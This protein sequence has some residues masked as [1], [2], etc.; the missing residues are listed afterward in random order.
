MLNMLDAYPACGCFLHLPDL[1][2]SISRHRGN[3]ERPG[4]S[5]RNMEQQRL[6][7][8]WLWENPSTSYGLTMFNHVLTWGFYML[9]QTCFDSISIRIRRTKQ[10]LLPTLG[11]SVSMSV[12]M[13][14]LRTFRATFRATSLCLL[15]HKGEKLQLS[16][17]IQHAN[18]SGCD[19][20]LLV[21]DCFGD[22]TKPKVNKN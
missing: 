8:L 6:R 20:P 12:S 1:P 21:D 14:P 4:K 18:M 10:E 13:H 22:E 15:R 17:Q 5:D 2:C 9:R 11:E 19:L 7:N 3:L 16:P